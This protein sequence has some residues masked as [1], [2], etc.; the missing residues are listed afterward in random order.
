MSGS[1]DAWPCKTRGAEFKL[2]VSITSG[3]N[4]VSVMTE[5]PLQM[6]RRQTQPRTPGTLLL[7]YLEM[8][9]IRQG[10]KRRDSSTQS[11][12]VLASNRAHFSGLLPFTPRPQHG[13]KLTSRT[14]RSFSFVPLPSPGSVAEFPHPVC[15]CN[16]KGRKKE[17]P[18]L[19]HLFCATHITPWHCRGLAGEC[20]HCSQRQLRHQRC[21]NEGGPC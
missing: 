8:G 10:A 7:R 20:R 9:W 11:P 5:K 16:G 14:T 3:K 17:A 4:P 15:G 1:S 2:V 6:Q 21:L 13:A 12:L 18:A 19:G